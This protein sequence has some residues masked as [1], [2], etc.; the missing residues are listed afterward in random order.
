MAAAMASAVRKLSEP[1]R[2]IAALPALRQRAPA[3]AV[4]FGRLSKMTPTT[5][6]GTATRSIS[7]PFGRS[8]AAICRPTGSGSAPIFSTASAMPESR[9]SSRVSRSMSALV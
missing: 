1:A 8:K 2:R 6:S 3:S 4:T 9:A 7:S 5:P